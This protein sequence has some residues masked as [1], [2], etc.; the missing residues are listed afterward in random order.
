MF[1]HVAFFRQPFPLHFP[2]VYRP[3][4]KLSSPVHRAPAKSMVVHSA[5]FRKAMTG[6]ISLEAGCSIVLNPGW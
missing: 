5:R 3:E 6:A 2:V 4:E 1:A